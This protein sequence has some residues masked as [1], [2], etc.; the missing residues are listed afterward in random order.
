MPLP[1]R[2]Y[3]LLGAIQPL[4]IH[5]RSLKVYRLGISIRAA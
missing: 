1:L 5:D 3:A 4:A 2:Y